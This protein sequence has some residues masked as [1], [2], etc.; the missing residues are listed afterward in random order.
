MKRFLL[1]TGLLACF[2][3]AIA[4]SAEPVAVL[5]TGPPDEAAQLQQEVEARV[6]ELGYTV[7]A[8]ADVAQSLLEMEEPR[9]ERLW[10]VIENGLD[11]ARARYYEAELDDVRAQLAVV[12]DALEELRA[13]GELGRDYHVLQMAMLL[14]AGDESAAREHARW[15]LF[16]DLDVVPDPDF[17]RPAVG[18][19][20]AKE[21]DLFLP[22][23]IELT[24]LPAGATVL[25][26]GREVEP[27]FKTI[28]TGILDDV[29]TI[30]IEVRAPKY[31]S[32][33]LKLAT[34]PGEKK[35]IAVR[36]PYALSEEAWD[37]VRSAIRGR[38]T[39]DGL[40]DIAGTFPVVVVAR[41]TQVAVTRPLSGRA[42]SGDLANTKNW[43]QAALRSAT[44]ETGPFLRRR[45]SG[46]GWQV[47]ADVAAGWV[48]RTEDVALQ[49][50]ATIDGARTQGPAVRVAAEA[51]QTMSAG[52][53]LITLELEARAATVEGDAVQSP[54]GQTFMVGANTSWTGRA[55]GGIEL[56]IVPTLRSMGALLAVGEVH[57]VGDRSVDYI[58]TPY[59][60]FGVGV[61]LGFIFAPSRAASFELGLDSV[62]FHGGRERGNVSLGESISGIR[63][64]RPWVRGRWRLARGFELQGELSLS[65]LFINHNG[66]GTV[67]VTPAPVDPERRIF[68][69]SVLAS[70]RKTF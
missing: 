42:V 31:R 61:R 65:Y 64:Q 16:Y 45:D 55:A 58:T 70:V 32:R 27:T 2:V 8:P 43:M 53:I 57:D 37:A 29:D 18:E 13:A 36:L 12:K 11:K 38:S 33:T 3:P 49:E 7:A 30:A 5:V 56:D 48:V 23:E 6:T 34:V 24:G 66:T 19:L 50:G 20:I 62:L 40:H 52:Q 10:R 25:L 51:R 9:D 39:L 28:P 41:G 60:R 4:Q 54:G 67:V 17:Y 63:E 69:V 26:N 68:D 47:A 22:A 15:A 46:M 14:D 35:T 44:R 1:A 21:R 59:S